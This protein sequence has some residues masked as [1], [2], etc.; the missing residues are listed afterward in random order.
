M[1]SVTPLG[2]HRVTTTGV[3]GGL[4][5]KGTVLDVCR[6]GL[7]YCPIIYWVTNLSE[8]IA[9]FSFTTSSLSAARLVA[10]FD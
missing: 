8:S 9:G 4:K 2:G 10:S 7:K 5:E 6:R 1:G 3:Q